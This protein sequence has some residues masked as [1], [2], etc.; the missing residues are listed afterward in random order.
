MDIEMLPE[1]LLGGQLL[2]AEVTDEVLQS[3][4][5]ALHMSL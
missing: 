2:V 1:I 4:V 5:N 3:Q